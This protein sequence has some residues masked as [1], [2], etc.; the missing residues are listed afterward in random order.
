MIIC[1]IFLKNF[2]Y[3]VDR[4]SKYYLSRSSLFCCMQNTLYMYHAVNSVHWVWT[5]SKHNWNLCISFTFTLLP[6][7]MMSQ[8]F[9]T[10]G[11]YIKNL[12]VILCNKNKHI[13]P[14]FY[15]YKRRQKPL[16]HNKHM[17]LCNF[18][19]PIPPTPSPF[20]VMVARPPIKGNLKKSCY[21][22]TLLEFISLLDVSSIFCIYYTLILASAWSGFGRSCSV[23]CGRWARL[24]GNIF[25][26][27]LFLL[28]QNKRYFILSPLSRAA[29]CICPGLWSFGGK[30]G[31]YHSMGDSEKGALPTV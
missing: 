16:F 15:E 18:S 27:H 4:R 30:I 11:V 26:L 12:P 5:F 21:Y 8:S 1:T 29:Q 22:Q 6:I 14:V 19:P 23:A 3:L 31:L 9:K 25:R 2:S 20:M 10:N 28:M 24:L 17:S 13:Y 7:I